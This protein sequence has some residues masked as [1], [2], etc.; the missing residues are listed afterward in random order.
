MFVSRFRQEVRRLSIWRHGVCVCVFI[1][2]LII[3]CNQFR[4]NQ[5][6]STMKD[7]GWKIFLIHFFVFRIV[8]NARQFLEDGSSI[9][10]L[11]EREVKF[12]RI[13]IWVEGDTHRHGRHETR[14]HLSPKRDETT[15]MR[16]APL[17]RRTSQG[18]N[19]LWYKNIKSESGARIWRLF[20]PVVLPFLGESWCTR[21]ASNHEDIHEK[22]T[23]EDLHR[24]KISPPLLLQR[25]SRLTFLG[26]QVWSAVRISWWL[27]KVLATWSTLFLVGT[28]RVEMVTRED[29]K[30]MDDVL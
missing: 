24:K 9:L 17:S 3:I 18:M 21:N 29:S 6:L 27:R 13:L 25:K 22:T 30:K 2:T 26:K 10:T 12:Q 1:W 15:I 14:G 16:N 28:L 23:Y 8:S 20:S 19:S 11:F 5:G 4:R 7:R